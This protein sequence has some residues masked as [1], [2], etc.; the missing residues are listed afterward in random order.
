[1]GID[2]NFVAITQCR[3][4]NIAI[5][6]LTNIATRTGQ[7]KARD[8][9]AR[10]A[11]LYAVELQFQQIVDVEQFPLSKVDMNFQLNR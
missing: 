11:D 10:H 3:C 8:E 9:L 5:F 7:N 6:Q 2:D 1:M 4:L